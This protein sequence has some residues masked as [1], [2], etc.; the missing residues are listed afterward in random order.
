M[1]QEQTSRRGPAR[2]VALLITLVFLCL[3][4]CMAVAITATTD[5][6]LLGARNERDSRQA[7]AIAQTGVQMI[8]QGV[9]GLA[10]PGTH[11]AADMHTAIAQQL[12]VFFTGSTMLNPA[13]IYVSPTFGV[14]LP[15]VTV[16]RP[17]GRTGTLNLVIRASGGALDNTTITIQSTARL[18][19]RHADRPPTT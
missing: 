13:G 10:V 9:G 17:D 4:A 11:D 18:W 1:T 19:R 7:S 6:G 15:T 2:G 14:I 16:A 8:K 5:S 3:F 12:T